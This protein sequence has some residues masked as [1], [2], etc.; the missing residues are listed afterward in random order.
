VLAYTLLV[1]LVAAPLFGL[2]PAL[3][4]SRPDLSPL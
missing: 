1:A 2:V 3:L 4:A